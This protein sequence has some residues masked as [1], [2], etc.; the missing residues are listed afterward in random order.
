MQASCSLQLA[1]L[2][3]LRWDSSGS[4][5]RRLSAVDAHTHMRNRR[6]SLMLLAAHAAC[7]LRD[8]PQV[9]GRP[10]RGR[11]AGRGT[12]RHRSQ[13]C[14]IMACMIAGCR[15]SDRSLGHGSFSECRAEG[16]PRLQGATNREGLG[17]PPVQPESQV[18]DQDARRSARVARRRSAGPPRRPDLTCSCGRTGQSRPQLRQHQVSPTAGPWIVVSRPTEPRVSQ[19][20]HCGGTANRPGVLLIG[21]G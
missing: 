14:P 15:S 3:R 9:A 20:R 13:R 2:S 12:T 10:R 18:V 4:M 6:V 11:R 21:M 5:L 19:K 16:R 17:G 8:F 7:V 1:A